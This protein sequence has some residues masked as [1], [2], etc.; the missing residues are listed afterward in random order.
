MSDM[1]RG[2][3]AMR[4]VP[5]SILVCALLLAGAPARAQDF[6]GLTAACQPQRCSVQ[7]AVQSNCCTSGQ[8]IDNPK[9]AFQR[10]VSNNSSSL[11]KTCQT[12]LQ[13]C[14][15]QGT[16]CGESGVTCMLPGPPNCA[17][18]SSAAACAAM[19]GTVSS[20]CSCC[21]QD[22][23]GATTTSTSSTS[24]STSAPVTTS[25]TSTS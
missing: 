23:G 2:Y 12:E 22:C 25:S 21:F 20:S 9:G 11:S 16:S 8:C 14:E 10:C 17:R 4:L 18:A 5:F 1:L 15:A 3:H 13:S 6:K 7:S 24:T 19:G